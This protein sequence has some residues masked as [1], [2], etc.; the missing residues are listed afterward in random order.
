MNDRGLIILFGRAK[1]L[2]GLAWAQPLKS[3]FSTRRKESIRKAKQ[4]I[5]EELARI[6]TQE[7]PWKTSL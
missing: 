4:Q 2:D 3:A 1:A 7:S 5:D 6:C